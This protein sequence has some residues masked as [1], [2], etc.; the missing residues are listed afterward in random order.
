MRA[1]P[2]STTRVAIDRALGSPIV[3]AA[4]TVILDV[5]HRRIGRPLALNEAAGWVRGSLAQGSTLAMSV[6]EQLAALST[7]WLVV[8]EQAD[9]QGAIRLDDVSRG[10]DIRDVDLAAHEV[11]ASFGRAGVRVLLVED[12]LARR[13]DPNLGPDVGFVG[14]RVLRWADIGESPDLA[15]S[16][17]RGGSSGYPLNAFACRSRAPVLGLIPGSELSAESQAKI[18]GS[19]DAVIATVYDAEA[20]VT[21]LSP[22][23]VASLA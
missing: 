22:N 9:L 2:A 15:T 21:L 23:L 14:D 20:Y 13:G 16:L 4:D 10:L 3:C 1:A 8:S 6:A 5:E 19:T 7:A 11:L 12:D 18:V 17:L